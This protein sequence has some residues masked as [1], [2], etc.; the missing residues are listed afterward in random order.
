M[1]AVQVWRLGEV[2]YEEAWALQ[3]AVHAA[4]VA[5]AL[6][7]QLLLLEHPHTL[8]VGTRGGKPG[9]RWANLQAPRAALEARGVALVEA[10]RGGDV[11]WHGPGQLVG[12][13]ILGLARYDRDIGRYV[14]GLE[15]VAL[16]TLRALGLRGARDEGF[17]GVW[18]GDEKICAIGARVRAW[19]TLHGFS[20]NL[21]GPLEGFGWITPCGLTGRGVTS[22]EAQLPPHTTPDDD[23]LYALVTDAFCAAFG[24]RAELCQG[25]AAALLA[26]VPDAYRNVSE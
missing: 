12:Y 14:R 22:V 1:R 21:R 13:P 11:T 8:T 5:E 25:G 9:G 18:I 20:I 26:S 17:P 6:P 19:T 2:P 16:L 10:D 4:R 24:L 23:A 3:R 7:D 15:E